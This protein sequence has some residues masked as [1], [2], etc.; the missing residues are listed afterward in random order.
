MK[1]R[2]DEKL[3]VLGFAKDIALARAYIMEGKVIVNDQ[4]ADKPSILVSSDD[5][6]RI[7]GLKDYVSRAG[8]KLAGAVL[9]F[10]LEADFENCLVLD[11]G[12]STGGFTDCVLRLGATK[13]VAVDVGT[14]QL[15][16]KLR[17]DD[18]V[19]SLE[20]TDIRV[21]D[22]APYGKFDWVLADVSFIDLKSILPVI[23]DRV[24]T[25]IETR[26]VLLVKPQFELAGG[27]VEDGGVVHDKKMQ[28]KAVESVESYLRSIGVSQTK[29]APSRTL[30]RS[31][32]QEYFIYCF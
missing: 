5:S 23:F 6:V 30:G 21:F 15:D 9:D 28:L 4:L 10:G 17:T 3:V 20:K 31:G 1:F 29:I 18:R 24:V 27:D 2:L 14:N 11:V 16:W 19:I 7:R 12:S 13:V 26:L 25:P 32:N 8:N 22:P